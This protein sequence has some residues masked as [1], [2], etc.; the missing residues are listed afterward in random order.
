MK[1]DPHEHKFAGIPT[2]MRAPYIGLEQLTEYDVGVLGVPVDFCVSYREGAR[3]GP[4]AIREYSCWDS[5]DGEVCFDVGTGEWKRSSPRRIADLGDVHVWTGDAERT[6]S[7]IA[8]A[9]TAIRKGAF[10][11]ILGGD[12]SITYAAVK[13]CLAAL[14]DEQRPLGIL[15][16]DAHTDVCTDYPGLPR[17]WHGNPFRAL[18]E[19]GYIEGKNL[20]T[21]GVRGLIQKECM[22]FVQSTGIHLIGMPEL[23]KKG[24]DLVI[25]DVIAKLKKQCRSVYIT[26]DIDCI[27]PAHAPGTGTPEVGGLMGDEII[28]MMDRLAELPLVAFDLTEVNPVFDPSARTVMV[29]C[30]LLCRFLMFGLGQ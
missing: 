11:L 18:I 13:G 22:D 20:V 5:I 7:E 15:H 21:L 1:H 2:F 27:D 30:E 9:V 12:H 19:E 4:R 17:V 28:P 23:K 16:F 6:N 29:A 14:R 8:R 25:S 24:L 10:P 3:Y 26:L